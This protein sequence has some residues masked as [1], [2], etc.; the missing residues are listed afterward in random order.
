MLKDQ[1]I[2]IYHH[3]KTHVYNLPVLR[4][5]TQI[6]LL[7]H[8]SWT[9]PHQCHHRQLATRCI[10]RHSDPGVYARARSDG[11]ETW[12]VDGWISLVYQVASGNLPSGNL[13]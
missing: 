6:D 13:T 3:C 12:G 7:Q 5:K 9:V 4:S 1:Y 11:G 8:V 10:Q 2:Y